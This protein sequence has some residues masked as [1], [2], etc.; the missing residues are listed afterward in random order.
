MRDSDGVA[1]EQNASPREL[2]FLDAGIDDFEMLLHDL[3]GRGVEVR[4]LDAE[5]DGVEQIGE[6]LAAYDRNLDTV[7]LV[8]HGSD[9]G[10]QLGDTWLTLESLPERA[11]SL[12]AWRGALT[13]SADLLLYG[14]DLAGSSEGKALVEALATLTGADVAASTDLTGAAAL[15]G[16]WDLEY[17]TGTVESASA[18]A[19]QT[20]W[21]G[22]LALLESYENAN[23]EVEIWSNTGN[24][25]QT[26]SHT[27]GDGTYTVNSVS[28]CL[29]EENAVSS[30]TVTVSLRE[31]WDGPDLGSASISVNDLTTS[32]EWYSFDLG[33]IDLNDGQSY[34]IRVSIDSPTGKVYLAYDDSGTY[35]DGDGLDGAGSPII[36]E[37]IA[38]RVEGSVGGSTNDAP[39]ADA[40]GP[41]GIAEGDPVTLDASLST[42]LDGDLLSYAWDIDG[43]MTY[44]DVTG[45]SP[46]LTWAQLRGFGIDDD[47]THTVA[48]RV[49][50][51]KGG[52]DTASAT[53]NVANT[54]PTLTVAG[55][56]SV[57][58]DNV[59]TLNLIATDPG[60]DAILEWTINWGDG[61]IDTVGDV[62]SA[63]HVYTQSGFTRNITVS[64]TDEDGTWTNSDLIVGN[65]RAGSDEFH[66]FDGTTGAFESIAPSSNE[67]NKP[68]HVI[69]GPDGDYYASG[70]NSNNIG[71]YDSS[72][73]YLGEFVAAGSG[74]L[75]K[76]VGLAFGPDGNLYV[77]SYG[78]SEILRFDPAGNF[79][80]VFG[81]S[82][83]DISG[84]CGLTFGPDGNLY[85]ASWNNG[86][87]V[88]YDGRA[89]G[90]PTTVIDSGLG[91]PEQIVFDA[92][93]NLY[94]SDGGSNSVK[95]WD[96]STLTTYFSDPS[97]AWATGW[98]SVRT[99]R[100]MPPAISRIR[101]C[102]TTG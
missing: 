68:Y 88:K 31:S 47:G 90:V 11:E 91:S 67:L 27:G 96:G 35:P 52:F 102:A 71:R 101:S 22:L 43:D 26:F 49:D 89:G 80:D 77:A 5:R 7:H 45:V 16:D 78:S 83:G 21:E 3:L 53:I 2:V 74:G 20:P 32:M 40:G 41:Y 70:Y 85:A 86:K 99:A 19:A 92:A 12:A 55:P 4:V 82:G 10:V 18:F 42:D 57:E 60:E 100:C 37:D 81:T 94:I 79:I 63:T 75:N 17:V 76:P 29:R 50:D 59:Y 36:A 73:N 56:P 62:P 24:R 97:L 46:T 13:G 15:G 64:A 38:F 28:V 6:I 25:G 93:G 39:T 14:C 61:S 30:Q 98:P 34:V 58:E 51:G 9:E 72:G 95:R 69:V 48:V 65:Y 44:G 8:S 66:R 87:L 84:P 23:N 33:S 1:A 54:A